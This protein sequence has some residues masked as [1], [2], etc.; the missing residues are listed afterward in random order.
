M[1]VM[2][3]MVMGAIGDRRGGVMMLHEGHMK[4]DP[5]DD[6]FEH[7]G[8]ILWEPRN[9]RWAGEKASYSR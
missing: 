4:Q 6:R 5:S 9:E 3:V 1:V 8:P 2:V 7:H